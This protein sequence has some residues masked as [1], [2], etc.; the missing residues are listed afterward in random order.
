MAKKETCLAPSATVLVKLGS[1][2]VHVEEM[3]SKNGHEVDRIALD[4]LLA[5]PE[6]KV[7]MSAMNSMALLPVKR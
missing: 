7:W 4:Q 2:A 6:L 1:I 5:D 3:L